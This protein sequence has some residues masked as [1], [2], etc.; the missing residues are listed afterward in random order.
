MQET[1]PFQHRAA[2][3]IHAIDR[4][5]SAIWRDAAGSNNSVS[6]VCVLNLVAMLDSAD[7]I[8]PTTEMIARLTDRFPSRAIVVAAT[9]DAGPP[10]E[11][12]VQAHCQLPSPGRPQVCC[13][14]ISV[15]ARPDGHARLP[16]LILPLLVPDVPVVLWWPRG[17][18]FGGP[19][20]G[21]LQPLAD[22]IIVDSRTFQA[23]LS[24][25][26]RLVGACH[27]AAVSDLGWGR[28]TSWRELV[29]QF[30]DAP[31]M[32]RHL[33]TLESVAVRYR[34]AD[35][36]LEARMPALLLVGWLAARLGWQIA[37]GAA[38]SFVRPDGAP[39]QVTLHAQPFD[40][41][42]TRKLLGME[43][44]SAD[45]VFTIERP[46]DA[47]TAR[48][49]ADTG[50]KRI[51]RVIRLEAPTPD[52]LLAEELQMQGRDES[53]ERTVRLV[54]QLAAQAA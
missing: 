9:E 35:D 6:R 39:V 44:R 51:E 24:G 18:P 38:L 16:G 17:E 48:T 3:D 36:S 11:A 45:G 34:A 50:G 41:E 31:G 21:R 26:E 4:T 42:S 1:A 25:L 27:G 30:F 46:A 2:V 40:G 37:D 23:G 47:P 53:F 29:A 22:H 5:L 10:L 7:Q 19:L 49:V 33:N 8:G 14:Q 32:L 28:L 43:L 20:Y 13:E 54:G 12:W 15:V 52:S